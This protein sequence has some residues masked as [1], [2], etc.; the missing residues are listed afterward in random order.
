MPL[1]YTCLTSHF[2]E[3]IISYMKRDSRL[4]SFLHALLRMAEQDGPTTSESLA[5][6]LGI[7]PVVVRR[8]MGYLR[9]AGIVKSDRGYLEGW[10]IRIDL[11]TVALRQRHDAPLTKGHV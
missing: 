4:S 2:K 9:T 5:Q 6:C 1:G 7:H 8:T 10:R 11:G 3:N